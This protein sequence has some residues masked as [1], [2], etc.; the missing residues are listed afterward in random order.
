MLDIYLNVKSNFLLSDSLE[1][2]LY[3]SISAL[4]CNYPFIL[5]PLVT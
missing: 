1:I 5:L 2:S 3:V 4:L